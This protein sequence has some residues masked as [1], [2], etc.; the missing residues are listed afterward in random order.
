ML[1]QYILS[2]NIIDE[3]DI[4]FYKNIFENKIKEKL[5]IKKQC[6]AVLKNGNRC[7]K[8]PEDNNITCKKHNTNTK[9]KRA[10]IIYHNH[11]PFEI[12][13]NCPLSVK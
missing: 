12:C 1:F 6:K 10:N 2:M 9:L 4:Q 11:L 3:I 8:C 13:K 7:N 5:H